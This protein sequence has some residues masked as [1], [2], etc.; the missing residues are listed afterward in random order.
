M[1]KVLG[2]AFAALM[3]T[4]CGTVGFVSTPSNYVKAGKEV[5]VVKKNTNV[6]GLTAMDAQE[7]AKLALTELNG[8]CTDGVTN[9]VTTVSASGLFIF[10]FEKLEMSGNCK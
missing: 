2:L 7:E 4:S 6:L 9:V 3:L 1:K 5:S 10:G 8:K